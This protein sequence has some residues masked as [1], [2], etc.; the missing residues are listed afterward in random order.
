MSEDKLNIDGN[1]EI[2]KSH[3]K[4]DLFNGGGSIAAIKE[5]NGKISITCE[6]SALPSFDNKTEINTTKNQILPIRY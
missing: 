4:K 1:C 2:Q 5:K 3:S 6:F